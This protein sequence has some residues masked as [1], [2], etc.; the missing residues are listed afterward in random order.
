MR[1]V[2]GYT[3]WARFGAL[4]AARRAECW[5]SLMKT[6]MIIA[7]ALFTPSLAIASQ[8]SANACAGK[9]SP[10]AKAIYDAAAPGFAAAADPK[11]EVKAKVMDLV[12]A[13]KIS[14]GSARA[15][16]SA[17]GDCLKALR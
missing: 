11:A 6:Y 16:A 8:Q 12:S 13:G 5:D 4:R 10:D 7:V 1:E 9:L 14:R 15:S 17:A 3:L 2:P